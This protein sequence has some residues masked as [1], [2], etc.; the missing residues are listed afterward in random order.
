MSW[1]LSRPVLRG[2]GDGNAALLPDFNRT[3]EYLRDFQDTI[4]RLEEM[5]GLGLIRQLLTQTRTSFGKEEIVMMM[6]IGGLTD[7]G[8]ELLNHPDKSSGQ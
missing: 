2:R 6:V 1:K 3:P 8:L 4:S 7:E 5:K